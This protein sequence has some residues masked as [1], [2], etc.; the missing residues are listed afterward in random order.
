MVNYGAG[1]GREGGTRGLG[2]I[3]WPSV[4]VGENRASYIISIFGSG[5][6]EVKAGEV[7]RLSTRAYRSNG[8]TTNL[9][10]PSPSP[11]HIVPSPSF[12]PTASTIPP[13]KVHV[14]FV[15]DLP[16]KSV[17]HLPDAQGRFIQK[18]VG[19]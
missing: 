8:I 19:R 14:A 17:N 13:A 16:F 3:V 12:T 11:H 15:G 10:P 7:A 6:T 18:Q 4:C 9:T 2:T 1:G 5:K